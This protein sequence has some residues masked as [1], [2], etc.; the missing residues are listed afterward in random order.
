MPGLL[1]IS[2]LAASDLFD[3]SAS[4]PSRFRTPVFSLRVLTASC[5]MRGDR[6][7]IPRRS[8]DSTSILSPLFFLEKIEILNRGLWAFF[9]GLRVFCVYDVGL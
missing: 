1:P 6:D 7:R 2:P 4:L 3:R 9:F 5:L 8:I